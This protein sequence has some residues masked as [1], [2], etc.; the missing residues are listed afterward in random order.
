VQPLQSVNCH[1]S[2]A[3]GHER[4][5]P[6]TRLVVTLLGFWFGLNL[7]GLVMVCSRCEAWVH[8]LATGGMSVSVGHL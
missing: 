6:F 7:V 2:R 1:A 5:G 4:H 3:H 8:V